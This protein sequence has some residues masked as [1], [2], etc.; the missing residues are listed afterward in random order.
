MDLQNNTVFCIKTKDGD[1]DTF[2]SNPLIKALPKRVDI[3]EF[4]EGLLGHQF[5][6]NVEPS[7]RN[8]QNYKMAAEWATHIFCLGKFIKEYDT[9]WLLIIDSDLNLEALPEFEEGITLFNDDAKSYLVDR[10]TAQI[11]LDNALI[12]YT[13]YKN[14]LEDLRILELIHIHNGPNFSV[15]KPFF[16][17]EYFPFILFL[18]ILLL[19]ICPFYGIITE[20]LISLTKMARPKEPAMG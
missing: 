5:D 19:L 15:I 8:P 6:T 11:I 2:N 4:E 16:F 17:Y 1:W 10:K 3:T 20:S 14:M 7:K 13:P 18:L 12:Y 9:D